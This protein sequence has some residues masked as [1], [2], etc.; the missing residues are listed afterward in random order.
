L[1][2]SSGK[3]LLKRRVGDSD[4]QGVLRGKLFYPGRGVMDASRL[5][6]RG[7]LPAESQ[8]QGSATDCKCPR[9]K[10]ETKPAEGGAFEIEFA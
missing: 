2:E 4:D 7:V 1:H 5:C 3:L 6:C 9:R 8:E 10:R